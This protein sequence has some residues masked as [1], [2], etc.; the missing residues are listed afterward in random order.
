MH[1][2][3]LL[4]H[5][6]DFLDRDHIHKIEVDRRRERE[7]GRK[8]EKGQEGKGRGCDMVREEERRENQRVEC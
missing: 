6:I 8:S 7:R 5:F 3:L 4:L 2:C 1:I